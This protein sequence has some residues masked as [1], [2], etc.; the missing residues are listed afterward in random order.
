MLF[1]YKAK[2]Q[3]GE[4][5]EGTLDSLNIETAIKAVQSRGYV[6]ISVQPLN[7]QKGFLAGN[8]DFFDRV[9]TK[10]LVILSR[11]FATLS[12]A[13]VS[14]LRIFRLLAEK[15]DNPLLGRILGQISDD[16]QSGTSISRALAQHPKL[17]SP[18]YINVIKAGEESGTLSKSFLYLADYLERNYEIVSKV[19]GALFYP[20]FVLVT[21]VVVMGLMLTFVIPKITEILIDSGQELPIFTKIVIAISDFMV[22]SFGYII[23]FIAIVAGLV[24]QYQRTSAGKRAFDE[25]K[26]SFPILGNLYDKLFLT[27]ICDNLSTMI[28]SGLTMIQALEITAEVVENIV[29]REVLEDVIIRVR[30][31]SSLADAFSAHERIPPVLAQM[32]KVGEETGELGAILLTLSTFYRREV[33]NAVAVVIAMIEP[34]MIVLLGG[35]VGILIGSVLLPIYNMTGA[36]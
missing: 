19:R 33:N 8:L 9:T 7:E 18:F 21:F 26:L 30:G 14:A 4:V 22:G 20:I 5:R 6:V 34:I 35:G 10:E 27:R 36:F 12:E 11:Q 23:V 31:G 15:N 29:Y 25:L 28:S 13:Q 17:F 16:L 2:D 24:Y 1:S 32:T 3:G